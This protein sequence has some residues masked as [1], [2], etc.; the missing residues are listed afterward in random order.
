MMLVLTFVC[1]ILQ[2]EQICCCMLEYDTRL[3]NAVGM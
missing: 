3:F 2:S 1:H